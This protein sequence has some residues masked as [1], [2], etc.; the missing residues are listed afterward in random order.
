MSTLFKGLGDNY[1]PRS[2][3]GGG[4]QQTP[5]LVFPAHVLEV[6]T[7]TDSPLYETVRDIGK[8]K[9]RDL[10]YDVNIPENK[11]TSVAYPLDRSFIRYP[12]PGEQVMIFYA[13]SETLD[14]SST[15]MQNAFFYSFVVSS[16][17]NISYNQHP[18]LGVD[19]NHLNP[20]NPF[21]NYDNAK[22]RFDKKTND[23][24]SVKD[25]SN[26]IKIYKQ[27]EPQE[28]DYI[29][30]GRF[31][32]SVRMSSTTP[33][34]N[35]QTPWNSNNPSGVSGDGIIVLRADRDF[36]TEEKSMLTNE[37]IDTDDSSI[38]MCTSQKVELTLA[39]SK[40][41]LSW[42]ARYDLPDQ[43]T[44]EA[45]GIVGTTKDTSQLWQ[46]VVDTT[47]PIASSYQNPSGVQ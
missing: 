31:G 29:I 34:A 14:P 20:D 28:G 32:T 41:L 21:I 17:H 35:N 12:Y 18:F 9:F 30:Q 33:S 16:F 15:V 44:S 37:N 43:G 1:G 19:I 7:G 8:I 38:Y 47:Q 11:V 45:E 36:T 22:T 10:N 46:K 4:S 3:G 27:L 40:R 5:P 42:R 6:C 2:I 23:I 13:F 39:C 24:N 25:G 26:K